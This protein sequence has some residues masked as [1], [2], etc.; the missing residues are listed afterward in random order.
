MP[1]FHRLRKSKTTEMDS[2]ELKRKL[3]E[4]T[5]RSA[6]NRNN[7]KQRK[8][9]LENSRKQQRISEQ[10]RKQLPP[11]SPARRAREE[12]LK[13]RAEQ[14]LR[15]RKKRRRKRGSNVVYYV[16]IGL[17][18][19]AIFAI[20]SVTVLFNTEHIIVVGDS[21]Y[22]AEEIVAASE[23]KGNENLVRLNLS[24][25]AE[26]IL[27]KLVCLDHVRVE[28]VYPS[29]IKITVTRSVPMANFYYKGKNFV[30]SHTGR[31]M[32]I[33]DD[34]EECMEIFGY[35]PAESVI[36]GSFIS[37]EDEQQ[38]ELI[39]QISGAVEAG[40]LTEKITSVDISDPIN[41][42]MTY[43]GRVEIFL[44]SILKIDQKIKAI[45]ELMNGGH[46][47]ETERITLDIS[48][49]SR[50]ITRPITTT[51]PPPPPE[52]VPEA[53]ENADTS[54]EVTGEVT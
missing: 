44:G 23:L 8:A 22:T 42:K 9:A 51:T 19:L 28:K 46:I 17:I 39:A 36:V 47:A 41:L 54:E 14:E 10:T 3:R 18:A 53:D 38:D 15:E 45:N 52:E 1:D 35:V 26:R 2:E 29:S 21:D 48:D 50:G 20:L 12:E 33:V 4:E 13:R 32:R 30:I 37:A 11:Q 31:V 43:D 25:T 24:G 7:N 49:P 16:A 5:E 27:N 6:R 40:G 34:N